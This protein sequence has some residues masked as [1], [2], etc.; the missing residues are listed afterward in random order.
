MQSM[1]QQL[2]RFIIVY[3]LTI[4]CFSMIALD[5]FPFY[6]SLYWL[7]VAEIL[8]ICV[9]VFAIILGTMVIDHYPTLFLQNFWLW[10][11]LGAVCMSAQLFLWQ[12]LLKKEK[13]SLLLLFFGI[14]IVSWAIVAALFWSS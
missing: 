5:E 6:R 8:S 7:I 9:G 3:Q 4:N 11:F 2:T 13:N 12:L 14:G 1:W 10:F